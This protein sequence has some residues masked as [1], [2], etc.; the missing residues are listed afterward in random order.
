[1]SALRKRLEDVEARRAFYDYC[2]TQRQFK[3]RT[4]DELQFFSVHGYFPDAPGAGVPTQ[5]E[6][7]V[8]GIRT[9]VTTERA[10]K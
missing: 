10:G 5:Y 9:V 2:E 4:R 7:T 6:F 8:G 3:G 1:M